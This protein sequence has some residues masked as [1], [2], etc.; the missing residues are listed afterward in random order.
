MAHTRTPD[1][2]AHCCTLTRPACLP[3]GEGGGARGV[4]GRGGGGG[5]HAAEW[6]QLHADGAVRTRALRSRC[7]C[8]SDGPARGGRACGATRGEHY[9]CAY[10]YTQARHARRPH[11]RLAGVCA[12]SRCRPKTPGGRH[13]YQIEVDPDETMG[14]KVPDAP[15]CTA[16]TAAASSASRGQRTVAWR[17]MVRDPR[18][19][20]AAARA[21]PAPTTRLEPCMAILMC[22]AALTGLEEGTR[23]VCDAACILAPP[24]GC[25]HAAPSTAEDARRGAT[26]PTA[27]GASR[28]A[29]IIAVDTPDAL[30]QRPPPLTRPRNA[31]VLQCG[32]SAGAAT[33][34]RART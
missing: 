18:L 19:L 21:A 34:P 4:A 29:L 3:V 30:G 7:V 25:H 13:A 32:Q 8:C 28:A 14:L 17:R 11:L 2:A 10:W 24:M 27:W 15:I 1:A 16:T 20:A 12:A 33:P 23:C 5:L 6:P 9:V 26:A 22:P 31:P